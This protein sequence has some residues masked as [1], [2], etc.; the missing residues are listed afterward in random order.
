VPCR[1]MHAKVPS[2][3]TGNVPYTSVVHRC[4]SRGSLPSASRRR[5]IVTT[6][7]LPFNQK[8]ASLS[9]SP[10]RPRRP[11]TAFPPN[12][13]EKRPGSALRAFCR[14]QG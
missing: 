6:A 12:G 4:L 11:E 1:R 14:R 7:W 5:F 10:R 9:S 13:I 3:F 2:P 8:Y